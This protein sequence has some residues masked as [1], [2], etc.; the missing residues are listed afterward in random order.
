MALDGGAHEIVDGH[1]PLS[2][3]PAQGQGL[4][5]QEVGFVPV[6]ELDEQSL[7]LAH[8]SAESGQGDDI[9]RLHRRH[10]LLE[11]LPV[12][13][14]RGPQHGVRLEHDG[15]LLPSQSLRERRVDQRRRQSRGI[16]LLTCLPGSQVAAQRIARVRRAVS[17]QR[18]SPLKRIL[19]RVVERKPHPRVVRVYLCRTP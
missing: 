13:H 11:G 19:G 17:G 4:L 6:A 5:K 16:A 2:Q 7:Q 14:T 8:I 9:A 18:R 3:R 10:R 15:Q 12:A 1:P